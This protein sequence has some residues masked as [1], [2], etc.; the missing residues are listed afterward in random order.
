M[1]GTKKEEIPAETMGIILELV[2]DKKR[3]PVLIH[4]KQGRHRTGCVVGVLRKVSGWNL[5]SILDEYKAYAEP[6][7]RDCD[8]TYLTGFQ[9]SHFSKVVADH[10][11]H[12]RP[13]TWI[14]KIKKKT[15]S[16]LTVR[17]RVTLILSAI[18]FMAIMMCAARPD[19]CLPHPDG[20]GLRFRIESSE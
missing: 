14:N 11:T 15:W 19:L 4:C 7:P 3:H 10:I 5:G 6:K 18:I 12:D 1:K 20:E 17:G 16:D 13:L 9:P 8:I 2:L